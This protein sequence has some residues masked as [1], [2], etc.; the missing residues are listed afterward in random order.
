MNLIGFDFGTTN[1][2]ISYYNPENG[3]LDC[4]RI[5]AS[6]NEYIPTVISYEKKHGDIAIG[7]LAKANLTKSAYE[8]H[9]HF[10]L[11][12]GA[13]CHKN[14]TGYDKTPFDVASDY[15]KTLLEKYKKEQGISKID[16]I[17]MTVPETWFREASNRLARE[18]IEEIY[19]QLGYDVEYQFQLESEPVAASAYFCYS[20]EQSKKQKYTGYITVV[21]YGGGTLDV[22]LCKVSTE[23][24][25]TNIKI[26][27]R[28]GFGEYNKTNGCAGVAFDEAVTERMCERYELDWKKGEKKFVR[29]RDDFEREK[30]LN[31][32][33]ITRMLKLY[34]DDPSIVEDEAVLTIESSGEEFEIYA[35]DL[36][37]S[38][39]KI[40]S[41]VLLNSIEQ[42]QS[43][44]PAHNVDPSDQEHFKVLLVGGF[45]NFYCV[46]AK[47]REAFGSS[48]GQRDNRF[49]Q[50]FP[51]NSK[52][53]AIAKG[54]AI[55]AQKVINVEHTCTH[56]IGYVAVRPDSSDRW[57]D[58]DVLIIEKGTKLTEVK[59]PIYA[60]KKVQVK[61]KTG[62]LRIF[63]DDARADGSGR[64]Q[65]ALDESVA[66]LFPNLDKP[67]NE[68]RIGF[69][70]DK[71]LIPTIHIQDKYGTEKTVSL[72][73]LLERISI[74]EI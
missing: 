60:E 37:E 73:R 3:A 42:M 19:R 65:A 14:L 66:E 61:L 41:P 48:V 69:S 2:T 59:K 51:A 5:D 1:S 34:Y 24:N 56:N 23:A 7:Q 50:A 28:C 45:S 55:I 12:L 31:A 35:A 70:V 58:T 32:D 38:F 54:A 36:A 22:T 8:V 62:I 74:R 18:N 44:F 10:K 33:A 29:L 67:D 15:I 17:V 39:E 47:A 63:V 4:F 64:V 6:A 71:N 68:Y 43:F 49:E 16:G 57:I 13:D 25:G 9:E 52:S 72:N 11:R 27:E 20:Y 30:I 21:D 40:N 26:L 53:L 46:E